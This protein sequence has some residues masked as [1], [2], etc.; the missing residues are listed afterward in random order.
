MV[1]IN[2]IS[3]K[4]G[5][6]ALF[7]KNACKVAFKL[8]S[9]SIFFLSDHIWNVSVVCLTRTLTHIDHVF[10]PL[11]E[12]QLSPKVWY[13]IFIGVLLLAPCILLLDFKVNLLLPFTHLPFSFPLTLMLLTNIRSHSLPFSIILFT[14]TMKTRIYRP[15]ISIRQGNLWQLLE[16]SV[17]LFYC[18]AGR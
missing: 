15:H 10:V 6:P 16:S 9:Y 7:H 13:F 2:H 5:Q 17:T 3:N 14:G 1:I 12:Y 18:C 11:L 4:K 8:R